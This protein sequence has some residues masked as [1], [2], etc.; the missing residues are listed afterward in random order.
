MKEYFPI[1]LILGVTPPRYEKSTI[2]KMPINTLKIIN[3]IPVN[4]I[5]RLFFL[6]TPI[7]LALGQLPKPYK[8][9]EHLA[10]LIIG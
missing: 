4:R 10:V 3:I 6:A 7:T 1:L 8:D 2:P 5:F 9:I